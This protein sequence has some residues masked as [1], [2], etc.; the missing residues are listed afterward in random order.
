ERAFS[1][2]TFIKNKYRNRLSVS[3]DLRVYLSSVEPDFKK[4]SASKQAQ[5][6][7]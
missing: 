7:H 3:S 2:Y 5:G 4:L 1:S 6:S